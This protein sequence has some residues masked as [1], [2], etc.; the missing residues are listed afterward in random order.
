MYDSTM[1]LVSKIYFFY[2]NN[3]NMEFKMLHLKI[4]SYDHF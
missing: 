1:T 4:E 2:S 3:I